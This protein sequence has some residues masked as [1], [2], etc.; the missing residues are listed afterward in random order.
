MTTR[1]EILAA[2]ASP[3]NTV[4]HYAPACTPKRIERWRVNGAIKLWKTRPMEFRLPIKF[5]L[6]SYY[7]ITDL[8]CGEFH[9]AEN[10]PFVDIHGNY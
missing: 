4:F 5:G 3:G 8:N 9:L 6:R 7:Y 1:D 2:L 10:C